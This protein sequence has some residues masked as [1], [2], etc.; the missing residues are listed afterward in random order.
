MIYLPDV[1]YYLKTPP[2]DYKK[3]VFSTAR[4]I[5]PFCSYY[6]ARLLR[7]VKDATIKG[8]RTGALPKNRLEKIAFVEGLVDWL[9]VNS[10]DED[11]FDLLLDDK[12]IQ[13]SDRVA[14]FDH[15]SNFNSWVLNIT[16][17][18]FSGIQKFWNSEGFP[19]DLFYP[20]DAAVVVSYKTKPFFR[21]FNTLGLSDE[22]RETLTPR[23]WWDRCQ[24]IV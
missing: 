13:I 5:S 1:F 17:R 22:K 11:M 16:E 10:T 23:Q 24:Q 12:P 3:S 8:D 4:G 15:R 21:F 6:Y 20:K 19:G 14:K 18:E 9:L 2:I 7:P